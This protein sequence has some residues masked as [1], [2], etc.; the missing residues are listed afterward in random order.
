M[1]IG[2]H[3]FDRLSCA[4]LHAIVCHCVESCARLRH[5]LD[6][7]IFDFEYSYRI[8]N[9]V[10]KQSRNQV[11]PAWVHRTIVGLE[12]KHVS[13]SNGNLSS[14]LFS[15]DFAHVHAALCTQHCLAIGRSLLVVHNPGGPNPGRALQPT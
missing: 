13:K 11:R 2:D 10:Q 14:R 7:C 6:C 8:L 9:A 4:I 1:N 12:H 5:V 15:S 3:A